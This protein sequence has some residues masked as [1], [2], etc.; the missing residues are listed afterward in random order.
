MDCEQDP[1]GVKGFALLDFIPYV[2]LF[3]SLNISL[4]IETGR[5]E[6]SH[7][8]TFAQRER[9]SLLLVPELL[10]IER[11]LAGAVVHNVL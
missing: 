3:K 6:R 1:N 7:S 5:I 11:E 9:D 10:G 2:L 8:T 4:A